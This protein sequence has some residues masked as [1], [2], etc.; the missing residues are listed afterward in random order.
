MIFVYLRDSAIE[1]IYFTDGSFEATSI[2]EF[3]LANKLPLVSTFNRDTASPIF[4]SP[5]KNKV[6]SFY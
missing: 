3:V 6:A 2:S 1:Y 4:E 5:I